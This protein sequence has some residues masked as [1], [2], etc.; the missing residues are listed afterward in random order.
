MTKKIPTAKSGTL[1]F[2]AKGTA[3]TKAKAPARE[4]QGRWRD[5][6]GFG[7]G[8]VHGLRGEMKSQSQLKAWILSCGDGSYQRNLGR[9]RA[10]TLTPLSRLIHHPIPHP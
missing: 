4:R 7:S 10:S 2:Q 1:E 8:R 6:K 5:R 3:R 9:I